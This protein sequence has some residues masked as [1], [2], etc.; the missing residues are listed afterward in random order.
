MSRWTRF[1]AAIV[2]GVALGL[3]YGWVLSPVEYVD[4]MPNT[5]RDDYQ[6]DY[7]LMVAEIF[8]AEGDPVSAEQRL[9]FLSRLPPEYIVQRALDYGEQ[10]DYNHADVDLLRSLSEVFQDVVP[11]PEGTP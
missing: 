3:Y 2:F 11:V 7:V 1:L 5:L 4:T 8:H 9:T 6:T 10:R